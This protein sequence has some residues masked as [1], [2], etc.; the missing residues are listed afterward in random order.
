MKI[1]QTHANP[2]PDMSF[3]HKWSVSI[4]L[5]IGSHP[6]LSSQK[7]SFL[8]LFPSTLLLAYRF[9]LDLHLF[10]LIHYVL[11]D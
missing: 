10:V 8:L 4:S 6:N 11:L 5:Y 3:T 9:L 1:F 7:Q 2:S